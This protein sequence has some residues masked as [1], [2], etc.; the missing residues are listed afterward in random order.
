MKW[1]CLNSTQDV[2]KGQWES[3]K[4]TNYKD[5]FNTFWTVILG[6]TKAFVSVAPSI[7]IIPLY[8]FFCC[9]LNKKDS[10]KELD[11]RMWRTSKDYAVT[12][13]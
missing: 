13:S 7:L 4:K 1:W 11:L 6:K 10:S 3:R 12:V 2:K 5:N 8:G 9:F